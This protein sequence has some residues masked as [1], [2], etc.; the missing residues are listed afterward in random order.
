MSTT[1]IVKDTL[2]QA[3]EAAS[4][5][6]QT[7]LYTAKGQPSFVNIIPKKTIRQA[8]AGW[9]NDNVHPAFIINGVEQSY[10]Y[11]GTY[12][13]YVSNGELVSQP[14]RKRNLM[15]GVEAWTKAKAAGAN[16]HCMTAPEKALLAA[17][18]ITEGSVEPRGNSGGG[19]SYYG[20]DQNDPTQK[21]RRDDGKEAIAA[22]GNSGIYT[23]S[24]PVSF[25]H[26]QDFNGISDLAGNYYGW[27]FGHRMISGEFQT[28][29]DNDFAAVTADDIAAIV[30]STQYADNTGWQAFSSTTAAQ[31]TPT[32]TGTY[33]G[34]DYTPT[35][36]DAIK[37]AASLAVVDTTSYWWT[38]FGSIGV[39]AVSDLTTKVIDLPRFYAEA[40]G[41][42]PLKA[43]IDTGKLRLA[44]TMGRPTNANKSFT[45]SVEGQTGIVG[46]SS[47]ITSGNFL[48]TSNPSLYSARPVYYPGS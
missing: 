12:E 11:V 37:L 10:L 46:G 18:C 38:S 32:F 15:G 4:N 5:G 31:I 35:T 24:G 20:Y 19:A 30:M 42:V 2:R 28:Y 44:N 13:G 27:L 36:V 17:L 8:F 40:C 25:R 21:G 7:V 6:K 16:W 3:V 43:L 41:A 23:G 26:N 9:T 33:A 47:Q 29:N 45:F 14:N 1:I 34:G 39:P 22:N 48:A